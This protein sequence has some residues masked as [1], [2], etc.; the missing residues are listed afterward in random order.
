MVVL[1]AFSSL[2]Q[3]LPTSFISFFSDGVTALAPSFLAEEQQ[4]QPP[5]KS[6]FA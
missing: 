6:L 2:R 5:T 3:P 4:R 1:T